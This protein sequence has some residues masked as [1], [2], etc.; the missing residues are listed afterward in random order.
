MAEGKEKKAYER[1]GTTEINVIDV[2]KKRE[3]GY[4][5]ANRGHLR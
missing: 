2:M 4:E 3:A 1:V 5:I